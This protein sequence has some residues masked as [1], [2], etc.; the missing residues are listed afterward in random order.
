MVAPGTQLFTTSRPARKRR[1]GTSVPATRQWYGEGSGELNIDPM[2]A[3]HRGNRGTRTN[4]AHATSTG[5]AVKIAYQSDT[6]IGVAY[7]ELPII[8][9]QL[10]GGNSARRCGRGQDVDDRAGT[11]RRQRARG[12]HHRGR[13]RH[14]GVGVSRTA[15]RAIS[16]FGGQGRR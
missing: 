7:D 4:L 14:P 11:D 8:F 10:D 9:G 6:D 16:P 2:L 5:A 1:P 3:L 15:R 13:R 12:V